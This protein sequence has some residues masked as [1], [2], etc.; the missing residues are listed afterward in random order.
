VRVAAFFL[1]VVLGGVD[2]A[3]MTVPP[4]SDAELAARADLV[5]EG[6]VLDAEAKWVGRRIVTFYAI[7]CD[8]GDGTQRTITVAVPGGVVGVLGQRVPGAPTL[9]KGRRYRLFLGSPVGPRARAGESP[10]RGIVGFF[11]GVQRVDVVA[12]AKVMVPF[13]VDGAPVEHRP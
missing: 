13:G 11:R 7:G 9:E 4:M 6:T 3:A 10:A 8:D 5:V 2:A 12:G 1:S